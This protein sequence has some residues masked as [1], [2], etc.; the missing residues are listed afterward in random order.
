MEFILDLPEASYL[1]R[2][3]KYRSDTSTLS[4]F[5]ALH[6]NVVRASGSE[7]SECAVNVSMIYL[8]KYVVISD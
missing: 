6:N 1:N 2:N 4:D 7:P 3:L 5:Q 8:F